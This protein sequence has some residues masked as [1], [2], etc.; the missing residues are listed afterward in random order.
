[1]LVEPSCD[2]YLFKQKHTGT[3]LLVNCIF[4]FVILMRTV[5]KHNILWLNSFVLNC[6]V[7]D[8]LHFSFLFK[9][10]FLFLSLLSFFY[11]F[12]SWVIRK[13]RGDRHQVPFPGGR[14]R[15]VSAAAA[16]GSEDASGPQQNYYSAW[17]GL[18][19]PQRGSVIWPGSQG[20]KGAPLSAHLRRWRPEPFHRGK[21]P[22]G[23]DACEGRYALVHWCLRYIHLRRSV[24]GAGWNGKA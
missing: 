22:A 7:I 23:E 24:S 12:S 19:H 5:G 11:M 4:V 17:C 3:P 18:D 20:H 13:A 6:F 21:A 14:I 1:M 9:I 16:G 15:R 8:Q 10:P 2:L